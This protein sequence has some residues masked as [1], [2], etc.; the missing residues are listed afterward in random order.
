VTLRIARL[1]I[2]GAGLIAAVTIVLASI[3]RSAYF[4]YRWQ[5]PT[6][7]EYPSFGVAFALVAVGLETAV[8]YGVLARTGPGRVWM[9]G[10]AGLAVLLLWGL[11]LSTAV[12]HAPRFWLLHL[13]WVWTLI[14]ITAIAVVSSG[15]F[16][17]YSFLC[18]AMVRRR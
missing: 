12:M 4:Y 15:A 18:G 7:W 14:L 1:A 9:R 17:A 2:I 13:I 11:V 8:L 5:D 10:L 6:Q 16:H 3:D